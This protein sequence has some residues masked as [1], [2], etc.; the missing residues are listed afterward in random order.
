MSKSSCGKHVLK[1]GKR[2]AG[3]KTPDPLKRQ[4]AH[5]RDLEMAHRCVKKSKEYRMKTVC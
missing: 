5:S 4:M 1:L 3:L 2:A